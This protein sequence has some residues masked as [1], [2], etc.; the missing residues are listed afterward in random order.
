MRGNGTL[1]GTACVN[2]IGSMAKTDGGQQ[3]PNLSERNRNDLKPFLI[4]DMNEY[5]KIQTETLGTRIGYHDT[6]SGAFFHRFVKE[7]HAYDR[8]QKE[9]IAQLQAEN[10]LLRHDRD[11]YMNA[12]ASIANY[13]G[14]KRRGDVK[15]KIKRQKSAI[16]Q[17]LLQNVELKERLRK[18]F[19]DTAA[20]K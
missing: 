5:R 2:W 17:L 1:H 15:D 12:L 7:Y 18:T 13:E 16:A 4:F 6:V 19:S 11:R 10:E 3:T 8:R 9:L 14:N 20:S